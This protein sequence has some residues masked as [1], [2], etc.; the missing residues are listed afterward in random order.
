[1]ES[2]SCGNL[3]GL[4]VYRNLTTNPGVGKILAMTIV[5]ETGPIDRFAKVGRLCFLLPQVQSL[6]LSNEKT[7]GKGNEKKAATSTWPGLLRGRPRSPGATT[8]LP[9][10]L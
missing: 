9:S 4:D 7:K 5:M 3:K 8:G 1:V 6:W 10:L 2:I